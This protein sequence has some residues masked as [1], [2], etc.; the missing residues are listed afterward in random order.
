M[1]CYYPLRAVKLGKNA[2]GKN[3]VRIFGEKEKPDW[4]IN[5][6]RRRFGDNVMLLPCGHCL[7]CKFDKAKD[8]ATRCVNEL[9]YHDKACFLT[10]TYNDKNYPGRLVKEHLT[11][12]I[13]ALRNRGVE[14]R[15]VGC[16]ELGSQ[17]RRAHYHLILFGYE[18]D[19]LLMYSR[20]EAGDFLYT[21]E[22]LTKLWDKGYVLV[23]DVTYQSCG[24]VAR[25]TTKK[26]ADDDCFLVCSTRPG[27]GY[28]Y[29]LDHRADMVKTGFVYGKFGDNIKA[30]IPRYYE[31]LLINDF[32]DEYE[33]LIQARVKKTLM[34]QDND[35]I[36]HKFTYPEQGK[37]LNAEV[38]DRKLSRFDRR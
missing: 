29:Y 12:F 19:D 26:I 37:L 35:L 11:G 21:S 20:S 16:G 5:Y 24:Y 32:P 27:I 36:N 28:R 15:Y 33:K 3:I 17:T 25:Y 31:K 8:W 10:L 13:K 2:D 34:Y 1:S 7:G 6:L 38:I 30:P 14:C 18:P 23:G 22:K 9:E 4:D